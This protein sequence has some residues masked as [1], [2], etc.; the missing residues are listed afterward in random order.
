MFFT[1][2]N[3][4][5]TKNDRVF[6][7]HESHG[8]EGQLLIADNGWLIKGPLN[9]ALK[10]MEKNQMFKELVYFIMACRSGTMFSDVL[11]SN[12]KGKYIVL[13]VFTFFS[14]CNDGRSVSS[15]Y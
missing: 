12:G 1:N 3:P 5:S 10:Y 14:L 11:D 2:M 7:S 6:V 9:N 13:I 8:Y 4:F 15:G